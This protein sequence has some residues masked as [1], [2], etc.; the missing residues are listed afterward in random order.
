VVQLLM[1]LEVGP[2]MDALKDARARGSII[3]KPVSED[4]D[5]IK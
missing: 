3:I 4:E 1:S 5:L 2:L